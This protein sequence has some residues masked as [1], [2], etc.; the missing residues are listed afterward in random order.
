MDSPDEA[1]I[2]EWI[3]RWGKL[4]TFT[5]GGVAY[6]YRQL[7]RREYRLLR[8]IEDE[9]ERDEQLVETCLLWP[10]DWTV[11]AHLDSPAGDI[12]VLASEIR[13]ASGCS[14]LR[15]T[16]DEYRTVV[17]T[18]IEMQMEATIDYV[19]GGGAN[20]RRYTD[21]SYDQ[22]FDTYARAEWVAVNLLG[23]KV[24]QQPKASP[25]GKRAP[26]ARPRTEADTVNAMDIDTDSGPMANRSMTEV[27]R[28]AAI[29]ARK[30][31]M[32]QI[33]DKVPS[34]TVPSGR[35]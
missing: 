13:V 22:L 14:D 23:K 29:T 7:T 34:S 4:F 2:Q 18:D 30:A 16:S 3:K 24:E 17:G 11:A 1:L 21:W 33:W 5:H 26:G 28:L 27:N 32:R 25:K 10:P 19:F 12:E 6:W 15:A 20:F 9:L 31:A 8:G 35:S